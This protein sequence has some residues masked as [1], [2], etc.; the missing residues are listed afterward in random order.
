[1]P[2]VQFS[3]IL[4]VKSITDMLLDVL[5]PFSTV[6]LNSTRSP[7]LATFPL[8]SFPTVTSAKPAS[9]GRDVRISNTTSTRRNFASFSGT[10]ILPKNII[11]YMVTIRKISEL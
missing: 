4:L 7:D 5:Y 6:K 8:I 9:A 1:M 2:A 10:Y 11:L 3:G